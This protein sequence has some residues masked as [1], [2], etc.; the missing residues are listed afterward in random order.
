MIR[1]KEDF[2][3]IADVL[4][5]KGH[6]VT[7]CLETELV[8]ATVRRLAEKRIGAVVVEDRWQKLV[9]IFSERDLVNALAAQGAEVLGREVRELMSAPVI[10]CRPEDRIDAVLARMTMARIRHMPVIE[11]GHLVGIVSIGDL[12]HHRLDEKELEAGVLLEI[13]RMRA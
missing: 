5:A 2:M 4:R 9:G 8:A 10:T 11:D 12:V 3:R 13:S 7:T 1:P 6:I